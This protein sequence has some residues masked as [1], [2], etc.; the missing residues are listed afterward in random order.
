MA[1]RFL[2]RRP[3]RPAGACGARDGRRA[4][5]SAFC[6]AGWVRGIRCGWRRR[7]RGM[8]TRFRTRSTCSRQ[9]WGGMRSS[10]RGGV[11]VGGGGRGG[12]GVEGGGGGQQ[13]GGG[14]G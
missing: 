11:F 7:G 6:R 12:V 8:D 10:T 14:G 9:S 3:R 13:G 1:S 4:R 2:F 5:S